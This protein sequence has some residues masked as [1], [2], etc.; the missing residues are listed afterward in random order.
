MEVKFLAEAFL[1]LMLSTA[2]ASAQQASD[3]I[4][5][6]KATD[7]AIAKRV[8]SRSFMVAAANPLAAEAGRDVIA[9][10]GNAIDA[11][12]AVQAALGLVEPQS[13]GLGGGAF[14]VYYNAK[15]DKLTTL[16]GRETAPMEATPKL[17][18][19]GNGQPLKFMDAVVGG[20]SVGTPGTAPAGGSPQTLWKGGMGKPAEAG[21][22]AGDRRLSGI[23]APCLADRVRGR[24][25]EEISAGPVLF[26]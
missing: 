25:A 9:A 6:E 3:T 19:D 4:A 1:V 7:V 14:L 12:V 23:T 18:L 8:E 26:L 15:S 11:M 13:S 2:I 17:F 20:R 21:A 24:P 16:D 22:N 10:G 5:P